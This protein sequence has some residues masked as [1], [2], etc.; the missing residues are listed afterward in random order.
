MWTMTPAMRPKS[1]AKVTGP[2]RF[3]STSQPRSPPKGSDMPDRKAHAKALHLEFVAFRMGAATARPSG[4]L[5]MAM[6]KAM[7]GPKVGSAT[8][9][10]K[11][12]RPSGKLCKAMATPE[13]AAICSMF[14][15]SIPLS[16]FSEAPPSCT[17]TSTSSTS[18]A[19]R[20]SSSLSL[21]WEESC[22]EM[23][24]ASWSGSRCAQ[25]T[26]PALPFS[27]VFCCM[28]WRL[29]KYMAVVSRSIEAK[30]PAKNTSVASVKESFASM[31]A[32]WKLSSALPMISTKET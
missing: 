23:A 27:K 4:M 10:T 21:S 9:A 2:T 19:L 26:S 5:W 31:P 1:T 8:A 20:G 22:G 17:A 12:A 11:V 18:S 24:F 30:S 29:K 25:A 16:G 28:L 13:N 15:R 6:A 3:R 14:T 7:E 32:S